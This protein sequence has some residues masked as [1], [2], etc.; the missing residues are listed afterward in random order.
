[1]AEQKDP[2]PKETSQKFTIT[3]GDSTKGRQ[4]NV[5]EADILRDLKAFRRDELHV[6]EK[7]HARWVEEA[8][9]KRSAT[10]PEPAAPDPEPVVIP[11]WEKLRRAEQQRKTAMVVVTALLLL[12][13]LHPKTRLFI[14]TTVQ[15][16]LRRKTPV[17]RVVPK[18]VVTSGNPQQLVAA[19]LTCRM[20]IRWA[21][22]RILQQDAASLPE[23][24]RDWPGLRGPAELLGTSRSR[25]PLDRYFQLNPH[26][27]RFARAGHVDELAQYIRAARTPEDHMLSDAVL[28]PT[29][30]L[31]K[32]LQTY[33]KRPNPSYRMSH[34][35]ALVTLET[36][37]SEAEA[38]GFLEQ[39]VKGTP[40]NDPWPIVAFAMVSVAR[41]N[42]AAASGP[43]AAW[44]AA[45]PNV[46]MGILAQVWV[47]SRQNKVDQMEA[48]LAKVT[49]GPIAKRAQLLRATLAASMG[50]WPHVKKLVDT[51]EPGIA[52]ESTE[53]RARFLQVKALYLLANNPDQRTLIQDLLQKAVDLD[54]KVTWVDLPVAR[55][56]DH[57]HYQDE[58][59]AAYTRYLRRFPYA[60]TVHRELS[61]ML[62]GSKLYAR[63]MGQLNCV[64]D[65]ATLSMDDQ[66]RVSIAASEL[67]RPDLQGYLLD[68]GSR[69]APV[70]NPS[71]DVPR[72]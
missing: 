60:S 61:Q 37:G 51:L 3:R 57:N 40:S 43:L 46:E 31:A 9:R 47:E 14:Q 48:I 35:A 25:D 67:N 59:L 63:A 71:V 32:R 45:H 16:L 24:L 5:P 7:D 17:R 29:P 15:N 30:E 23:S 69:A 62:I 26:P 36:G 55:L 41:G 6:T 28:D 2:A 65:S 27:S 42:P 20:D 44:N 38:L 10:D 66:Q 70:F 19:Y 49:E 13:L 18:E 68:R 12:G 54:R 22:P 72:Q 11:R 58:A 64:L 39:A 53:F 56:A 34:L 1:M 21:A 52:K 33:L 8:A 4:V 50:N